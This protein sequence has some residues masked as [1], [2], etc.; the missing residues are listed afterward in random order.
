MALLDMKRVS[1]IAHADSKSAVLKALQNM[2][3]VEIVSTKEEDLKKADLEQSLTGLEARLSNVQESLA[4]IKKYDN[5][6]SSFLTPKPVMTTSALKTMH[7]KYAE[8]DE[9]I[10]RIKQFTLDLSALKTRRQQLRNKMLQLDPYK[11]FDA[12]LESI[13]VSRYTQSLL[14]TIP[15][16]NTSKYN[17]IQIEYAD[18]AYF[19]TLESQP[20]TF[21]VYVIM[22]NDIHEKLTGELKFIGFSEAYTKELY[23]TPH[24]LLF[25]Y[26]NEFESLLK[27]TKEYDANAER[28][29]DDKPMLQA[30]EDHL[31]TEIARERTIGQLGET[32]STF[33]LE[34]WIIADQQAVVE[35]TLLDIAPESYLAFRDPGEKE[36][37]PTAHDNA[38]AIAPFEAVTDMYSITSSKGVDPNFI[39]AIFYFV[40]FGMMMADVAYGIILTVG[41]LLVL[42]LKKPDGMFR[43]ITSVIMICGISTALWGL[44]F[45]NFFSIDGLMTAVINPLQDA[46]TMLVLCIGIG[47]VHIL[48]GLGI[49]AYMN[50]RRG[51]IW[52]AVFDNA[53]WMMVLIG[54]GLLALGGVYA[55]VGTYLMILGAAVLLLTQGRHKKGIVGKAIGGLASLYDVTSYLSDILSYCRI[56]GMGLA[57][58]VIAMVFNRIGGMFFGSIP[59]YVIGVVIM[60]VGHVFNIAINTLGAF[61]HTARLQYIEFYSKF[62]EGGG[63]AFKPLGMRTKHYRLGKPS[64]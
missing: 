55:T 29:V 54:A 37:P 60:T 58:T 25:D 42:K 21:S 4:F 22:H 62:F 3:A 10:E 8:A 45:G 56:F 23:G 38:K 39:M 24:D 49:S 35:K 48:T 6:K 44:F 18:L 19:E 26:Q 20:D 30:M 28:F 36:I 64:R 51:K 47:V 31:L 12:S 32:G 53:S 14:G 2:G 57:T 27:E 52:A 15:T 59:G 13:G 9:T 1:L 34:G 7:E 11:K 46:M 43:K 16:E 41:S 40:I 63:H 61:V 50:I 5:A 33:L 17:N